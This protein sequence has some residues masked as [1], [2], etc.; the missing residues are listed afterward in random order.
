MQI[1]Y[2]L[3]FSPYNDPSIHY[4][5]SL[6]PTTLERQCEAH[7]FTE[8]ATQPP[9]PNLIISCPQLDCQITVKPSSIQG[10]VTVLDVF[11]AVYHGLRPA[12]HPVEYNRL[13]HRED[14]DAAYYT[15]CGRILDL[16][17]RALEQSKGIKRVDIL[18]GKNRFMGL[19]GTVKGPNIWELNVS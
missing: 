9:L 1:H 8:P 5:L 15:R 10:V 4:D 19:S 18:M 17:E 14:V 12:V 11:S 16:D 2:L 6:P 3:A 13:P 7:T